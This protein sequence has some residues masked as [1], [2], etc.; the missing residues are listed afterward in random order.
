MQE[1]KQALDNALE[2][3]SEQ[4]G[5]NSQLVRAHNRLIEVISIVNTPE[6]ANQNDVVETPEL[7]ETDVAHREDHNGTVGNDVELPNEDEPKEPETGTQL[8]GLSEG[9][10]QA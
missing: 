3:L 10:P 1:L 4:A 9:L 2:L 6:V 5:E 7:P 8:A